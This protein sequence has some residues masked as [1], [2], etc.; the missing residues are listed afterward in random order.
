MVQTLVENIPENILKQ[1]TLRRK[2]VSFKEKVEDLGLD[3][4]SVEWLSQEKEGEEET[5]SGEWDN[6]S[7]E[8]GVEQ[9]S[10]CTIIAGEKRRYQDRELQ[11][12][13]SSETYNLEHHD[14]NGG[15]E[16]EMIAGS[17]KPFREIS[18]S[19]NIRTNLEPEGDR[20]V[21]R[22]IVCIKLKD[23]I[24]NPGELN[25]QMMELKEHVKARYRLSDLI[26]AQNKD[27][28]TSNLSKWIRTGVKEKGRSGGGQL[29][30]LEQVL[31]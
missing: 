28:K 4:A 23:D 13:P 12:D 2:K 3:Q 11:T 10:L 20:E 7:V 30:D 19:L 9:D 15:E 31:Q 1:T 8:S 24:H 14:V 16:P 5:L 22:G 26:R 25:G 6:D 17:R 18:S 27:K 29:Q 21:L